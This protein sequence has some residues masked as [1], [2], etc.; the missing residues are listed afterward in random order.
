VVPSRI[1]ISGENNIVNVRVGC[2]VKN[3]TSQSE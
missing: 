3:L 1:S 2:G